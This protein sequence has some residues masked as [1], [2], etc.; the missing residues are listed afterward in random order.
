MLRQDQLPGS[1]APDDL[2]HA[3]V[4]VVRVGAFEDARLGH[5]ADL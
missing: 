4:L 3:A 2:D 5:R 1:F